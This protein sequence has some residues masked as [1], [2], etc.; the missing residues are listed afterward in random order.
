MANK[1]KRNTRPTRRT[2]RKVFKK[3]KSMNKSLGR[4]LSVNN[5][6]ITRKIKS[7]VN[8]KGLGFPNVMLGKVQFSTALNLPV[9]GTGNPVTA[10]FR[11]SSPYDPI[12]GGVAGAEQPNWFDKFCNDKL[13]NR[14][15]VYKTKWTVYFRNNQGTT[16]QCGVGT[17][18]DSSSWAPA[19]R[20]QMLKDSEQYN[21]AVRPLRRQE[22]QH[23]EQTFTGTQHH[24]QMWG[25]TKSAF[26]AERLNAADWDATPSNELRLSCVLADDAASASPAV[27][28]AYVRVG[29][30]YYCK[31]FRLDN[32]AGEDT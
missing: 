13:Y 28:N 22:D 3:K 11:L 25:V 9:D 14:Y 20:S 19:D 7:S 18:K 8:C 21:R 24:S 1:R 17:D 10:A 16:A 29:I 31:F 6:S 27:Q 32:D 26:Y 23:A 5:G 2:K 30:I 12:V 4:A 15:L